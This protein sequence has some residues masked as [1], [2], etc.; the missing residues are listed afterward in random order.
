[1][2]ARCAAPW[3]VASQAPLSMEFYREQYWSVLPFLTPLDLPDPGMECTRLASLA[4]T[5]RFSTTL[6]PGKP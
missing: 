2:R 1:M 4:L 5:G 3:T 6:P